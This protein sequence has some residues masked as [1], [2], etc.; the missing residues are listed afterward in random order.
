MLQDKRD[1]AKVGVKSTALLMAN[2]TQKYL[3]GFSAATVGL[4]CISGFLNGQGLPFYLATLVGG[5]HLAW[6]L[7]TVDYNCAKSCWAKFKSN[8]QFGALVAFGIYT[9]YLITCL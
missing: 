1:D 4:L 6:Q 3:T 9:D 5:T 2:D 7:T 8:Q